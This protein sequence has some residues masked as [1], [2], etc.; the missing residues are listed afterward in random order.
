M[1]MQQRSEV[2]A[3]LDDCDSTAERRS[4]RLYA[5]F[6]HERPCRDA[7]QLDEV[8]ASVEADLQ[9]GLHAVVLADYEF[10]RNLQ[11]AQPGDAALRFLLFREC[12]LLSR[13]E[14][15][16][17]LASRDNGLAEQPSVAGVANIEASVSRDAY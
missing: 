10:G 7:A 15:D 5:S 14:A 11:L 12:T 1:I 13:E 17:W 8:C 3:L 2:F 4:S 6:L 16:Q 9:N